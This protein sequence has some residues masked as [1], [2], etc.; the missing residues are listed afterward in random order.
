MDSNTL[1]FGSGEGV[2]P[3]EPWLVERLPTTSSNKVLT[4]INKQM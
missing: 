4:S 1:D 2:S 3:I